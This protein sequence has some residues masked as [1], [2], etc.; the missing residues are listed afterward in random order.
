MTTQITLGVKISVAVN[1]QSEYSN[2]ERE[3]FMFSYR[4]VIEN[5]SDQ[6]I[7]LK[8]R[9]WDIFDSIGEIT[10]V[11]GAGVVGEQPILHPGDMHEYVSGCNLKSDMG[12]M[13]GYYTMTRLVDDSN[14]QVII[15]RFNLLST[16]KLN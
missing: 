15:P 4:I 13:E 8:D 2:P 6:T 7:Q 14:F 5:Q 10:K 9:H 1:Y 3:H 11:D 16:Y 12:Y